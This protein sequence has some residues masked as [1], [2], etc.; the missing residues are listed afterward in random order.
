VEWLLGFSE[1]MTWSI[2]KI[3][4]N[5]IEATSRFD[6]ETEHFPVSNTQ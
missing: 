5:F 6:L 1:D 2:E 3:A 4:A